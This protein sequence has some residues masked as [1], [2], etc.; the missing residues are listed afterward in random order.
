MSDDFEII[1]SV[2]LIDEYTKEFLGQ[3]CANLTAKNIVKRMRKSEYLC[4][5]ESW[6]II[7]ENGFFVF[8][9]IDINEKLKPKRMFSKQRIDY[10]LHKTSGPI[11]CKNPADIDVIIFCNRLEYG[12]WVFVIEKSIQESF[13]PIYKLRDFFILIGIIIIVIAAF[14]IFNITNYFTRPIYKLTHASKKIANGDLSVSINIK[15][16]DEMEIL[17][18]S[19]NQ[20]THSLKESKK[21]LDEWTQTLEHKI[22]ERT[23]ELKKANDKL[24]E[25]NVELKRFNKMA[26]ARELKMIS[27][28]NEIER[29]KTN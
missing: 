1:V 7:D 14:I 25:K 4:K 23:K 9:T 27:L 6:Y 16:N 8:G 21:E 13:A 26:V 15:T 24:S 18:N 19:F 10:F 12:N 22:D 2:P 20:M 3:I 17:A 29:L 11:V 28:K 5:G